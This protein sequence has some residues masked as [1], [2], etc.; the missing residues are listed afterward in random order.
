M[1]VTAQLPDGH[2][3]ILGVLP[4]REKVTVKRFLTSIPAP[5]RE[6]IETLCTDMY[7]GYINSRCI[8][9]IQNCLTLALW[10]KR[11]QGLYV[12]YAPTVH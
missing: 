5:L 11:Q 8:N 3:V 9:D 6:T 7:P 12:D 4:D 10:L 2:L 1:I